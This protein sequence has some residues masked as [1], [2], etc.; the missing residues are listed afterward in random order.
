MNPAATGM[1][2]EVMYW[3]NAEE[4]FD[5]VQITDIGFG[6][7]VGGQSWMAVRDNVI[8]VVFNNG[9][10]GGGPTVGV[11][12]AGSPG[13]GSGYAYMVGAGG[14]PEVYHASMSLDR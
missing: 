9:R 12:P 5:S 10:I 6:T 13:M 14:G 11:F 1:H 4:V 3:T 7:A 8:H 2:N